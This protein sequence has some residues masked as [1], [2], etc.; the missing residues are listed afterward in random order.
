MELHS[1]VNSVVEIPLHAARNHDRPYADVEVNATFTGP[2]NHTL[3]VPAFWAGGDRWKVRFSAPEPGEWTWKTDAGVDDPGLTGITGTLV[4]R[5]YAGN[6]PLLRHGRLRVGQGGRHLEHADG[7]PFFWMGDTWW[8]GLSTRL[9]WPHGFKELTTDRAHKGYSVVQII[10]GPY[11]DMDMFDERGEG[12]G[13]F[14]FERDLSSVNPAYFDNADLRIGHLVESGL[15]PCIVGM[16]GYYILE[17]GVERVKRF[18]RYLIA[19]Y[20]AYPVT[21]CAAGEAGMAW[22]LSETRDADI[23]KQ[24]TGWTEVCRDIRGTDGFRN[25]LTVHPTQFGREQVDDPSVMDFEML[26]TGH[27]SHRSIVNTV[28]SVR[29]GYTAEPKMPT[30]VSEVNYEGIMGRSKDEIQRMCFWMSMLSGAMGHTYGANGIWQ[31]STIERPYGPSPHGRSWGNTPWREAMHLPGGAQIA[32]GAKFLAS[33]PW[34]E[35]EPHNEWVENGWDGSDADQPLAAGIPGKLRVIYCPML[36]D[37]PKVLG[38]EPVTAYDAEYFDPV[39]GG[40][41]EIG[42]VTPDEAGAWQA[43]YPPLMHDWVLVLK[44]S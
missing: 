21:W 40:I 14:P 44:R 33:L 7:T 12:D 36:W 30:F 2:R 16:W 27:S 43:P 15:S 3:V 35:I 9:D 8:M 18:W 6:N 29:K 31:M 41:T 26:Q 13:G 23:A 34:T 20:G 42:P 25:P 22:Y 1:T 37:G 4:A 38:I 19:R 39:E 24:K 32:R 17:L 28:E 11:P 5:E 10:A